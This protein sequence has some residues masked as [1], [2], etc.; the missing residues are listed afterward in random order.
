MEEY[1]KFCHNRDVPSQPAETKFRPCCPDWSAVVRF[2]LTTASA[3]FSC[4][5][6]LSSWDYRQHHHTRLIFVFLVQM[7]FLHV[8]QAGLELLTSVHLKDVTGL[9]NLL[10]KEC[11]KR[12]KKC[13]TGSSQN[14]VIM[15]EIEYCSVAGAGSFTLVVQAGTIS[16][17]HNLSIPSASDSPASVSQ[18]LALLPRLE[19]S[20]AISVHCNLHLLF[21]EFSCLSLPS[22][23]LLLLPRLE[24]SGGDFGSLQPVCWVQAILLLQPPE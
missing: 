14:F 2:R 24:C 4:L 8:G 20:D 9:V 15:F 1:D 6:L 22:G 12:K 19:C 5:S 23:V 21:K 13:H 11:W 18:S 3:R 17:H 16:V 10:L 7:G